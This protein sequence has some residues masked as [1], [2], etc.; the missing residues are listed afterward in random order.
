MPACTQRSFCRGAALANHLDPRASTGDKQ[1][2]SKTLCSTEHLF[3][4]Q[5]MSIFHATQRTGLTDKPPPSRLQKISSAC[6]SFPCS[7]C[8]CTVTRLFSSMCRFL[9]ILRAGDDS[10]FFAGIQQQWRACV[11]RMLR[12]QV[13]LHVAILFSGSQIRFRSVRGCEGTKVVTGSLERER[14]LVDWR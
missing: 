5:D 10:S 7:C 13:G 2:R 4:I 3:Q 1:G 11:R 9:A 12:C 14:R 8:N 6:V